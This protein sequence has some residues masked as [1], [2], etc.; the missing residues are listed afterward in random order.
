MPA[1]SRFVEALKKALRARGVTYAGL[2]GRIGLSEASVKRMFSRGSFTLAR[3]E[4]VL[5]ALDLELY[6]VARMSRGE[7]RGAAE[8][9]LEQ[10]AALA[11]DERL[12][13]VFWLL[14]NDWRFEEILQQFAVSRSELTLAFARLARAGLI[15]WGP[16]ERARLRVPRDFAWRARG[17]VKRAYG[18]RVMTEFL[19]GR[20]DGPAEMLRFE[21]KELSPE[22]AAV[23]RRKLERL[24]AEFNELAEVDAS[25]PARRR[26]STAILAAVRPWEFSVVNALK[27]R[28]AA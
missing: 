22:S 8:L 19:K 24:V 10:E 11:R 12:L 28:R 1:R 27:K 13:S 15:D 4:Q 7:P 21:A 17:P 25:L 20:F 23:M 9:T 2:A 16:R 3:I 14:L 6:D 18:A 5:R 26:A